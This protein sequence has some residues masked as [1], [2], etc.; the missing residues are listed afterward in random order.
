MQ[1]CGRVA[2]LIQSGFEVLGADGVIVVVLDIVGP[3]PSQLDRCA[4]LLREQC[5][6]RDVIGFRLPAETT[7]QQR[8]MQGHPRF[9]Q[10]EHLS[11]QRSGGLRVLGRRPDLA[12]I[13]GGVG[14]CG[15]HFHRRVR[16]MRHEVVGGYTTWRRA[17]RTREIALTAN[18][19]ARLFR[20]RL[21]FS[22][23]GRG[24]VA[25]VEAE[26]PVD[27]QLFSPLL[28][29]PGVVCDDCDAAKRVEAR[30]DRR[31][32]DLDDFF[33]A[34]HREGILRIEGPGAA[35]IDR[36]AFD[37]DVLHTRNDDVDAV[38]RPPAHNVGEIDDRH[39]FPDIAPRVGR[40]EAELHVVG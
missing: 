6:L 23:V 7:A 16:V 19:P 13:A 21:Q 26:I 24:V 11:D 3:A 8:D 37:R 15:R 31:G 2:L 36:A 38:G 1:P 32:L 10:P 4:E 17:Q 29:R 25:G 33:H 28:C 35:A 5:R 20:R 22:A 34:G 9:V 30:R 18:Q 27:L 14:N 39:G 12:V 40:L